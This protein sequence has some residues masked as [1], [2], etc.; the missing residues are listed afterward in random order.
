MA[1]ARIQNST[2][3]LKPPQNMRLPSKGMAFGSIMA[4]S[5]GSAITFL[6]T[7]SQQL[8]RSHLHALLPIK[9]ALGAR[10]LRRDVQVGT[11]DR[12]IE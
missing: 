9:D 10:L 8:R 2:I 6:L 5:R 3:V 1:P 12:A 11:V 7:L 4:A